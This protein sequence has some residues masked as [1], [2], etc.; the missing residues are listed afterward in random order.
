[1]SRAW[2]KL[3]RKV[4]IDQRRY[5]LWMIAV[6]IGIPV[7]FIFSRWG[8]DE[9]A[10]TFAHFSSTWFMWVEY[11]TLSF[12]P[13]PS[14]PP[15]PP[16]SRGHTCMHTHTNTCKCTWVVNYYL[17]LVS[18]L[19]QFTSRVYQC[20]FFVWLYVGKLQCMKFVYLYAR[21]CFSVCVFVLVCQYVYTHWR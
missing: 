18:W 14:S 12:L 4:Q 13:P 8:E 21:A 16:A 7:N 3:N 5:Y 11:K 10:C 2:R 6:L 17:S 15:P 20:I 19:G 9:L 1:M